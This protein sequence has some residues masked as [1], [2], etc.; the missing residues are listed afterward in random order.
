MPGPRLRFWTAQGGVGAEIG[1]GPHGAA[2]DAF[3]A[4]TAA[5]RVFVRDALASRDATR[6][7]D[8]GGTC[9]T[10]NSTAERRIFCVL[11]QPPGRAPRS[12]TITVLYA[13][14]CPQVSPHHSSHK[15]EDY[16][17]F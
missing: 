15:M 5:R 8:R 6:A 4:A 12:E 17:V 11:S 10:Y 2:H 16:G 13:A 14:G 1:V 9:V 3:G 7:A